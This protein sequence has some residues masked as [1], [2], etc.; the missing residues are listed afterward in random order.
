MSYFLINKN[1]GV[2]QGVQNTTSETK[3]KDTTPPEQSSITKPMCHVA[4]IRSITNWT[5]IRNKPSIRNKSSTRTTRKGIRRK[6]KERY[7]VNHVDITVL[8]ELVS[9][10]NRP[11]Y[12][13][14]DKSAIEL[15][16]FDNI[17]VGTLRII[18]GKS[19]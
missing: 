12:T 15:S 17:E 13:S 6:D 19:E 3:L 7:Y 8:D 11:K 5:C 16:E 1:R 10:C 14:E 4:G 18:L 9:L 2:D